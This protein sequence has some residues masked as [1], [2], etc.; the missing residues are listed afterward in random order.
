MS[1][2]TKRQHNLGMEIGAGGEL[3]IV[4]ECPHGHHGEVIYTHDE[5]LGMLAELE[6]EIRKAAPPKKP[7]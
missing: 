4:I 2:K 3:R 5:A 6:A 1:G 7:D